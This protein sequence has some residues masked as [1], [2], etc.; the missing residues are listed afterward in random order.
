MKL[1]LLPLV[2]TVAVSGL[3]LFGGWFLYQNV[4]VQNPLVNKVKQISAVKH[5]DAEFTRDQVRVKLELEPEA[6]LR[7]IVQRIQKDG[8]GIIGGRKLH[9]EV[10]NGS[11]ATLDQ[12]WSSALFP[13]AEAME[14][15]HYT[16][17]PETLE[18]LSAGHSNLKAS[19]E[20]D[21]MNVYVSLTDGNASK[22]VILPRQGERMGVW[23]NA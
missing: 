22:F 23:P 20:M 7:E 17:I 16:Q 15:K 13:V 6:S 19:T 12:W 10:T 5:A 11:S 21:D 9:V 18:Q 14:T 2:I 4:A 1:R 3:V 8:K